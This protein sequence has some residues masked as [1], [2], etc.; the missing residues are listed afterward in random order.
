MPLEQRSGDLRPEV[1]RLERLTGRLRDLVRG[2]LDLQTA[3]SLLR[4]Y[5][6]PASQYALRARNVTVAGAKAYD[7]AVAKCFSD[8]LSRDVSVSNRLLWLPVRMG[9]CGAA[10]AETRVYAAPWA[11]WTAVIDDLVKHFQVRD[12]E[13]LLDLAPGISD[14]IVSLHGS[15]VQQGTLPS[16]AYAPPARALSLGTSQQT[17]VSFIHKTNLRTV[18]ANMD[19]DRSGFLRSASG[20]GAGA[21]LDIP[22]D[23]R[24]VMSNSRY[25]TAFMRRLG[26]PWPCCREP[27]IVPPTCPNKTLSG[28]ICGQLCDA[29]GKHQECCAPGGGLVHRHD[30]VVRCLGQLMARNLDPRPRLEQIIPELARPVPGQVEQARLDIVGHDGASR[31]LVDVVVVSALAGDSSFRR[32]CARR[33]AH[34]ARRAEIAKRARYSSGDLVPFALETGGRLGTEARAFLRKCA[35]ASDE[36]LREILY[37]QRAV[38]SVLQSGIAQQLER[39]FCSPS[40]QHAQPA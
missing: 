6:G 38:S 24:W 15:L 16:V 1:G 20:P 37:L 33:D 32:A 30:G 8:L 9:G 40:R 13:A 28:R 18:R 7:T 29:Y 4:S 21:F 25:I 36:P 2:G 12:A 14:R 17:L 39:P 22:L 34:V 23:D 10:S 31:V 5:A 27:P 19:D 3:S 11:S 26:A 35:E